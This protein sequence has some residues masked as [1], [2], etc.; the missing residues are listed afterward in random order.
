MLTLQRWNIV[1]ILHSFSTALDLIWHDYPR[2]HKMVAYLS[3]RIAEKLGI[4][5]EERTS[6]LAAALLHD[7]G[8]SPGEA[9]RIK[10]PGY[11]GNHRHSVLCYLLLK[12]CPL[13]N[14]SSQPNDPYLLTLSEELTRQGFNIYAVNT[15]LFHHCTFQEINNPDRSYFLSEMLKL[16]DGDVP[17][18]SYILHLSDYVT[19]S[20]DHSRYILHQKREIKEK[21]KEGKSRFFSPEVADAFLEIV[22]KDYIWFELVSPRIDSLLR[23]FFPFP[24]LDVLRLE[25]LIPLAEL[26]CN[27]GESKSL[28]TSVHSRG[29]TSVAEALAKLA[30]FQSEEIKLMAIAGYLHDIGKFAIPVEILEKDE[31]LTEEEYLLV[32]SHIFYTYEVLSE[33]KGFE[34]IRDWAS[35]HHE[36]LDGSGYPFGLT[37]E[38]LSLGARIMAVADVFSALRERRP[39]RGV[40][41]S[42]DIKKILLEEASA[43]KLD[44]EVI[45]L[46]ISHYEEIDSK[47]L[48][49]QF[50]ALS[51]FPY[52]RDVL[53]R[54][55]LPGK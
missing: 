36:R 21:V 6:I 46:L 52:I 20:I 37:S 11:P 19:L 8:L 48:D 30:G 23:S 22:E 31:K 44:K 33:I 2:H 32:K 10:G 7:A 39:Y 53:L 1:D 15:I 49:A 51:N 16:T 28:F 40:L 5:R 43:G 35:F 47:L 38:N 41:E 18:G 50:S 4:K 34:T 13:L 55:L 9:R 14:L 54:I 24:H 42:G 29:V 3:Y 25:D 26:I 12:N 45:S 27:L 17:I